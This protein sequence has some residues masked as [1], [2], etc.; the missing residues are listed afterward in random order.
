MKHIFAWGWIGLFLFFAGCGSRGVRHTIAD[1]MGVSIVFPADMQS[2]VKDR[3]TVLDR[4]FPEP[5]KLVAYLNST[6]CDGC[7]LKDLLSWKYFMRQFDSIGTKDSVR[8]VFVFHPK[9]TA[10]LIERLQLYDFDLPVWIDRQGSFE[11]ANALPEEASFHVFLLDRDNRVVLVG[12]PV[13]NP[14]M[15]EL[16]KSTIARLGAGE[17]IMPGEKPER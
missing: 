17:G 10:A 2:K 6:Q 14:K 7:R 3:D 12:S 13:G 1:L 4:N 11:Q 15:W 16:Y 9:D 5:Y 8:F